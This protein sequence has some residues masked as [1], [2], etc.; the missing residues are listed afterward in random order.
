MGSLYVIRVYWSMV[1]DNLKAFSTGNI[2]SPVTLAYPCIFPELILLSHF[3]VQ[4]DF[5]REA[6]IM[7]RFEHKNIIKLLGVTTRG[8]PAYAIMEFMLYGML[9]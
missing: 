6:D 9:W 3:C 4:L 1:P 7:K 8:E 5:L 2:I